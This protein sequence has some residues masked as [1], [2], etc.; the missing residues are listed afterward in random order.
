MGPDAQLSE[1][2]ELIKAGNKPAALAILRDVVRREPTNVNG[3][4]LL[5]HCAPAPAEKIQSLE[6][7][8]RLDPANARAQQLLAQARAGGA[9]AAG[10]APMP[11][12][13][14]QPRR[15]ASRLLLYLVG[16]FIVSLLCLPL[17]FVTL[18]QSYPELLGLAGLG[19]PTPTPAANQR[20]EATP[21]GTAV[22]WLASPTL[23]PI[24][25][26]PTPQPTAGPRLNLMEYEQILALLD[27]FHASVALENLDASLD[28]L[29]QVLEIN[30]RYGHAYWLRAYIYYLQHLNS[31]EVLG[32]EA[33]LLA[34]RADLEAALEYAPATSEVYALRA[35]VLDELSY[36]ESDYAPRYLVL[37]QALADQLTAMHLDG[38]R[39]L[40]EIWLADLYTRTLHCQA[41]I[42]LLLDLGEFFPDVTE[43]VDY[44]TTLAIA[45]LCQ[46][47][48]PEA[49]AHI[50]A[51]CQICDLHHYNFW[52]AV[53]YYEAGQYTDAHATLD[54]LLGVHPVDSALY[55]LKAAAYARQ[56]DWGRALTTLETAERHGEGNVGLRSF[57]RGELYL[58]QGY[59]LEAGLQFLEAE[60]RLSPWRH[61]ATVQILRGRLTEL[62][63]L[64]RYPAPSPTLGLTL[65]TYLELNLALAPTPPDPG[66]HADPAVYS[67]AG[68]GWQYYDSLGRYY[69]KF[70]SVAPREYAAITSLTLIFDGLQLGSYTD[71][72][73]LDFYLYPQ[74]GGPPLRLSNLTFGEHPIDD[75]DRFV[76]PGGYIYLSW[77]YTGVEPILLSNVGFRLEI[78]DPAGTVVRI[79]R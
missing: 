14:R 8:L 41:A 30:P 2:I 43:N 75:P 25:P 12:G 28:T 7:A 49:I 9:G 59:R 34:A 68:V 77:N 15:S 60:A 35:Q 27:R 11:P 20:A 31:P 16:L 18:R 79:E 74:G 21:A 55:T 24:P 33:G 44:L 42:D 50:T 36:F 23:P 4:I 10:G 67:Y 70:K 51:A 76:H 62:G 61:P 53:I 32:D 47:R 26:T 71:E 39:P 56:G 57:V 72:Q 54:R 22:I 66:F 37:E 78:I 5:G 48:Y 65:P 45:Y 19:S 17:S 69:A 73:Q 1:A 29:T 52:K 38:R 64:P 6:T 46:E 3:W 40:D 13:A 58:Q 63:L